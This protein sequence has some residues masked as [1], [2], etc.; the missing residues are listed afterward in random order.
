M[1][2]G[3]SNG[4]LIQLGELAVRNRGLPEATKKDV[5]AA[6]SRSGMRVNDIFHEL[7]QR[8]EPDMDEQ[9]QAAII[10][11]LLFESFDSALMDVIVHRL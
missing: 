10:V 1:L 5:R 9:A 8:M 11:E 7:E 3:Y 6:L 2:G 4:D